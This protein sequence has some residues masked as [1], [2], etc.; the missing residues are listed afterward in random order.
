MKNFCYIRHYRLLTWSSTSFTAS[1]RDSYLQPHLQLAARPV[2]H[3][4]MSL[5]TM[6]LLAFHP[7]PHLVFHQLLYGKGVNDNKQ[8]WEPTKN[9]VPF[10]LIFTPVKPLL[11]MDTDIAWSGSYER[12]KLRCIR[13]IGW[14]FSQH[15][16][17]PTETDSFLNLVSSNFKS[18]KTTSSRWRGLEGYPRIRIAENLR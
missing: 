3:P 1:D 12:F 18:L 9:W 4:S 7:N 10:P 5:V 13:V 2:L 6:A 11:G 17:L 16:T 15:Y 14:V 8:T